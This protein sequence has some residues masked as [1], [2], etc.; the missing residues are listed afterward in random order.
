MHRSPGKNQGRSKARSMYGR[1]AAPRAR[2]AGPAH[3]GG[4]RGAGCARAAAA[5]AERQR[6]R[7]AAP[8]RAGAGCAAGAPLR[9]NPSLTLT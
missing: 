4:Q 5:A 1:G 9:L 6:R 7:A 3:A 8:L 2:R